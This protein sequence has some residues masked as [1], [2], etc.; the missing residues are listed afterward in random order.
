VTKILTHLPSSQGSP[1][2]PSSRSATPARASPRGHVASPC[3][4]KVSP[5]DREVR[6]PRGHVCYWGKTGKHL[7]DLSF[8]GFDPEETLGRWSG[9]FFEGLAFG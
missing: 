3:G 6:T 9:T 4:T 7:L 5:S 2:K 8:S 1:K